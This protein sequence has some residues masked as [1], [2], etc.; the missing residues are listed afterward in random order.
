MTISHTTKYQTVLNKNTFFFN[1]EPFERDF[2]KHITEIKTILFNL[3]NS[4]DNE[5]LSKNLIANILKSSEFGLDAVLALTGLSNETFKRLLT[6]IMVV[7][8]DSL[9]QLVNKKQWII[10]RTKDNC[11]TEMT[12]T[13][14][15]TQL[16]DNPQFLMGVVNLFFQGSSTSYLVKTLPLFELKKLNISKFD[17]NIHELLD[18]IVRYKEKGSYNANAC[19]NAEEIVKRELMKN[20]VSFSH[21][22]LRELVN[23]EY[24]KKRNMDFI[25]PNS[26]NPIVIIESS[27][28][29]TTSS[30]Q[31][32]KAKTEIS[33]GG[34]IKKH[35]PNA[36]FIGIVDGVGWY[37]RQGD[38]KRM[39]SAFDDVFTLHPDE[40]TRLVDYINQ[41]LEDINGNE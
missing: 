11:I 6:T 19:N 15:K 10:K 4:I 27:Y 37:V 31:G 28:L 7:E 17:F 3:K 22:D 36:S 26:N 33:I 18:T 41:K 39:V 2:E 24:N 34:L 25:I 13:Q 30:G 29:T 12:D 14:I 35:Y 21:G 1:N 32:D 40:M 5:R 23:N 38:L 16:R 20:G 9:S 8:D